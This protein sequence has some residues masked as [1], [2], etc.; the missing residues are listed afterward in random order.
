MHTVQMRTRGDVRRGFLFPDEIS[1]LLERETRPDYKLLWMLMA[2]CGL[3]MSEALAVTWGDLINPLRT[4]SIPTKSIRIFGKGRKVR[5]VPVPSRVC[6]QVK[7]WGIKRRGC[8]NARHGANYRFH[9]IDPNQPF[10]FKRRAVEQHFK[11][12]LH[13]CSIQRPYL[14]PHSLRHS[15]AMRLLAAGI[16]IYTVSQLLGH[17]SIS[18]TQEYL[19]LLPTYSDKVLEVMD[20]D[21]AAPL[22][23]PG[24]PG[25]RTMGFVDGLPLGQPVMN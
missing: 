15:Y 21:T 10:H 6:T 16:D 13:K 14:V 19:H 24:R 1:C 7:D 2:D 11:T 12:L 9:D 4:P 25:S 5:H 8:F 22:L 20:R 18:T 17:D 3:R 23:E